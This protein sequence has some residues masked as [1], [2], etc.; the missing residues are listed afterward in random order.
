MNKKT[1]GI[2]SAALLIAG[3]LILQNLYKRKKL[4]GLEAGLEPLKKGAKK[5]RKILEQAHL[6]GTPAQN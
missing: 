6:P 3:G 1:I 4:K 5:M 2:L